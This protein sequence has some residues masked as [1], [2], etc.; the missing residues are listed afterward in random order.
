MRYDYSCETC[1]SIWEEERSIGDRDKPTEQPHD[2][3]GKVKRLISPMRLSYAGIHS[4][5]KR[6]GSGWNDVLTSIK[7][8]SGKGSTIETR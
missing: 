7:K 3:G 5:L 1:N 4:N 2:C 8:A 6:A